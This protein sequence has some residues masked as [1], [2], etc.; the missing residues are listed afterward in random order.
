MISVGKILRSQ[1]K[2]G[3]LRVKFHRQELLKLPELKK[4]YIERE[5]GLK[6]YRVES[7]SPRGK[8]FHVKLEGVSTLAEANS[9]AGAEILVAEEVLAKLAEDEYYVHQLKGCSVFNLEGTKIGVVADVMAVPGNSLLV[10][11]RKGGEVLVPFH[12]SV[13][14]EVNVEE[15][16]ILIDPPEGLFDLDEI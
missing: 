5:G 12:V 14:R 11:E 6:E 3:E 4:I 15:K 16:R 9:L 1:G 13:C 10:V 2:E 8:A 7:F